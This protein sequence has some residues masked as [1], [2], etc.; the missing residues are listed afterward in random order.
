MIR[1]T[2]GVHVLHIL[3]HSQMHIF[4]DRQAPRVLWHPSK[5]TQIVF[6]LSSF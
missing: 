3:T 1:T 2:V 6:N 5:Y 4:M